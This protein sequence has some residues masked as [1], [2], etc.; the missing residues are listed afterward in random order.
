MHVVMS[1]MVGD[2][3]CIETNLHSLVYC[4]DGEFGVELG[5][6]HSDAPPP[7]QSAPLSPTSPCYALSSSPPLQCIHHAVCPHTHMV[8]SDWIKINFFRIFV[9]FIG[10]KNVR[11]ASGLSGT[12]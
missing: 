9:V 3:W 12:E 5:V 7:P 10:V 6:E 8:R 1:C 11:N 4:G 2:E